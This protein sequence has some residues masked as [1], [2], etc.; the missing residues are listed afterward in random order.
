MFGCGGI[1]SRAWRS[2]AAPRARTHLELLQ[3]DRL[4]PSA[5]QRLVH[6]LEGD[7]LLPAVLRSR[8]Q[9]SWTRVCWQSARSALPVCLEH[10]RRMPVC[11][12]HGSEAARPDGLENGELR[13]LRSR[14]AR[15]RGRIR[16][17]V[18]SIRRRMDSIGQGR[19]AQTTRSASTP[20]ERRGR[21]PCRTQDA[22]GV[23][24]ARRMRW[25]GLRAARG[26]RP[27]ASVSAAG[28]CGPRPRARRAHDPSR[29]RADPR[30]RPHR[31]R[32]RRSESSTREPVGDSA[33][34]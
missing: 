33:L 32:D 3:L 34:E 2:V 26:K 18:E 13:Q 30:P 25:G 19:H 10:A 4:G 28:R 24:V 11:Q 29:R 5:R 8:G 17:R 16:A 31:A 27:L 7:E 14:S 22:T 6:A 21:P 20:Y 1:A 15:R 23:R 9:R 12:P